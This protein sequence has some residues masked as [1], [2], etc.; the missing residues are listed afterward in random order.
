MNVDVSL[1]NKAFLTFEINVMQN[2]THN[3]NNNHRKITENIFHKN[4]FHKLILNH[5]MR[6]NSFHKRIK[7][8]LGEE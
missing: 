5:P 7:D 8:H 3:H 1:A 4:S 2:E 6:K